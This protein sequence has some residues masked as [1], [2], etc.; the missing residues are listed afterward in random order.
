MP[1]VGNFIQD[2]DK[3]YPQSNIN[4]DTFRKSRCETPRKFWIQSGVNTRSDTEPNPQMINTTFLLEF[5]IFSETG[6]Q[7]SP[8]FDIGIWNHFNMVYFFKF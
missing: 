3:N 1:D 4:L 8:F 2:F 7:N 5:I 6:Y